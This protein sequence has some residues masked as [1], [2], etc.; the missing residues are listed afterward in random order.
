MLR[1]EKSRK[2]LS[3]NNVI[4]FKVDL[5]VEIS[6]KIFLLGPV[7]WLPFCLLLIRL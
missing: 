6:S 7:V 2:S 1:V 5:M 4:L 3:G